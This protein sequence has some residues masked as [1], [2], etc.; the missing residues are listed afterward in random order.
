MKQVVFR[1]PEPSSKKTRIW[2]VFLPFKGCPGRCIYC[3]QKL[4]TA[5]QASISLSSTFEKLKNELTQAIR[6]N[7]NPLKLGFF[8]GTF[9]GLPNDWD[10][11]FVQLA[12]EFRRKGLITHIRCSTRPD[13]INPLKLDKLRQSG[14]DMVELG[15]QSFSDPVLLASKRNYTAQEALQACQSIHNSGLELGIQLLPGLPK[16]DSSSWDKDIKVT[17]EQQPKAVRIYPCL[18]LKGTELENMWRKDLYRPWDLEETTQ[19][20]SKGLLQLWYNHILVIRTG[21]PHEP[22]LLNNIVDGPWHPCLGSIIRSR[23]LYNYISKHTLAYNG[24]PKNL[25]CPKKYQGE[26]WGYKGANKEKLK[27]LGLGANNIK[28]WSHDFFLIHI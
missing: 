17:C 5:T 14:L 10:Q 2:P 23:V 25:F 11:R 1:S 9:T 7:H 8:G 15:I 12:Q 4:Q 16:H 19:R 6:N 18:V 26:I 24:K 20:L 21:L 28:F 3:A 13:F 27:K 22:D